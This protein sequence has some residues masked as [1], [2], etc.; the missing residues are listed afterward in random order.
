MATTPTWTAEPLTPELMLEAARV[1]RE[2]LEQHVGRD[3]SVPAG[4]LDW[5]CRET[6]DHVSDALGSYCGKL[7]LRAPE[8]LPAFRNGDP[9]ASIAHLLHSIST[10]AAMLAAITRA[11]PADARAFHRMGMSDAEGFL[12]MA[13]EEMLIHTW[14]ICQGFDEEFTAP[15]EIAQAVVARIFPWAPADCTAWQAQLWCSDRIE[16]EG[17]GRIGQWGWHAAPLSEW[18]GAPHAETVFS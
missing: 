16:L 18:S 9:A 11:T 10:G 15:D 8:Q 2:T 4:P 7:A 6:L 17:R 14:D 13:C 3:W 12:A 5:S 1:C